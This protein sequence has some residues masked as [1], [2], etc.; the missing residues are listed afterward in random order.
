MAPLV[1]GRAWL[2]GKKRTAASTSDDQTLFSISDMMEVIMEELNSVV[3]L[4]RRCIVQQLRAYLRE[5]TSC[6]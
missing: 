1:F 5:N 4:Y 2:L 3:L 6:R